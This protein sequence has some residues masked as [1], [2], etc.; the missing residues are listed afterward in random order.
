MQR[1][2]F[3]NALRGIAAICVV[4]AHYILMFNYLRGEFGGLPALTENPFPSMMISVFNPLDNLNMGA[5]GVALFFLISGL[6]IPISVAS[7][8]DKQLAKTKFVIGRLFRIWPTYIVGLLITLGALEV[9][10]GYMGYTTS[11]TAPQV[12][13]QMSLFRDWFGSSTPL[14]G[15]VWT[16]EVEIKFYLVVLLCWSM[17][18]RG[19][20]FPLF[21]LGIATIM[22]ANLYP[23]NIYQ[24]GPLAAFVYPIKY[25]FFMLIGVAFNYHFRGL[26]SLERLFA[27]SAGMLCVFGYSCLT[28]GWQIEVIVSY[29]AA[30]A[31]FTA[32]YL[33]AQDWSGG[34]VFDFLANISYPLYACHGA[35]GIVGMRIMI[36]Q[37][38]SEIPALITQT[39]VTILLSWLIHK[40]I[41]NPTHILGKKI[42]RSIDGPK[43]LRHVPL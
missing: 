43:N 38:I 10:A 4:I 31:L 24:T 7:L 1:I 37:G 19:K 18:G 6:V 15:V 29:C 14:D 41:E 8:Q 30:F 26:L 34:P 16:L 23:G 27:I 28:E 39:A 40:A 32:F 9:A 42:A 36:D 11:Y 33:L 13:M 3:A 25:I 2:A 35:F 5:F 21:A 22:A 17:I 12:L 20:L